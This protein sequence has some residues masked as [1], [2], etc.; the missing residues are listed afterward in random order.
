MQL[1]YQNI[2]TTIE[3]TEKQKL[4]KFYHTNNE[5]YL[6]TQ[7]VWHGNCL[8]LMW[9]IPDGSVDLVCV[10]LPYETTSL[11][12]DIALPLN[13][14]WRHYRRI[15]KPNAAILMFGIEPFSSKLRL[16]NINNYRYDWY[17]EKERIT[18][19]HQVKWRAGKTVETISVFY[20]KQPTYN[21]QMTKHDGPP[22]TNKVKN[23]RL[24]KLTDSGEKFVFEYKD[25][26]L[27]YPTQVLRFKRDILT[28]NLHPTQKPLALIQYLIKSYSNE[29]DLVLDNCAGSG[30]T[31]LAAANLNRQFIGIEKEEKYV[32]VIRERLEENNK[33]SLIK[34][35]PKN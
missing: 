32:E 4:M 35:A 18:N 33:N 7:E 17:W 22:R 27:R 31:L 2:F 34:D 30:T 3:L 19:I 5:P 14:L 12:W 9:K 20:E 25:N 23:G 6:S 28:C 1:C 13:E 10:D 21:P 26:G 15:C 29:G 8:D 16:S 11:S 24:G